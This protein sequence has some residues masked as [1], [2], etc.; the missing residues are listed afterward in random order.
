M[1]VFSGN[2][3]ISVLINERWDCRRYDIWVHE[4]TGLQMFNLNYGE[5]GEII[6]TEVKDE[7]RLP[8]ELGPFMT[9]N[10]NLAGF[11][12]KGI[13]E[14]MSG[15]GVKPKDQ[16]L[17]EGKLNATELHLSDMRQLSNKLVDFITKTTQ[18]E[19]I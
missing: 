1:S 13:M 17:I 11:L 19:T 6:R 15:K 3:N 18:N 7:L 12:F 10:M 8:Y 2:E 4:F 9:I 5:N 16:N 14:H